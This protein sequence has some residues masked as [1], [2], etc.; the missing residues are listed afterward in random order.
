MGAVR[1]GFL[2]EGAFELGHIEGSIRVCQV[3]MTENKEF[4]NTREAD[5]KRSV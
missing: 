2:E 5:R 4:Q 3:R 1:G